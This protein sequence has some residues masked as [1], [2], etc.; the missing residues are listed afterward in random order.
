VR[1]ARPFGKRP[2]NEVPR[3]QFGMVMA[4]DEH[5][6]P[7]EVHAI[8]AS[9]T[10]K[11]ILVELSEP[12]GKAQKPVVPDPRSDDKKRADREDLW[13]R[14]GWHEMKLLVPFMERNGVRKEIVAHAKE[15][16]AT[17]T[18]E[19]HKKYPETRQ[20]LDI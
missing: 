7:T 2:L 19:V 13:R 17:M 5:G 12:C 16:L 6:R 14:Y 18:E 1:I 9:D 15:L 11:A 20:K 3:P 10:C 8:E 4:F